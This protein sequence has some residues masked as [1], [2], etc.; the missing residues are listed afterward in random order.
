MQQLHATSLP[1]VDEISAAHS[2]RVAQHLREK[3]AVAGGHISFAAFMHEALY[4]PGLGYYSAGATKLG[5]DGDFTTAP[6]S[7]ALFGYVLA[8]QCA[9]VI[10]E[11]NATGAAAAILEFGA[12]S[13][14]LAADILTR[15]R[16]L[17][18]MPKS[19]Q[20]LEVSADLQARQQA[21][22]REAVPELAEK[23]CGLSGCGGASWCDHRQRGHR[24]HA[25]R[26]LY[27]QAGFCR[28]TLRCR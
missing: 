24:R 10:A 18:A 27:S 8:R 17:D 28:A 25:G 11:L 2:Q 12:G 9:P 19:Y 13:G 6:E 1:D 3:I 14:K 23:L 22:L 16:E 26:A 4:A 5:A 21:Y 15:L 20:I 7:S